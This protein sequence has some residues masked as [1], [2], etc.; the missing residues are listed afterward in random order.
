MLSI[1]REK[2]VSQICWGVENKGDVS[3]SGDGTTPIVEW[4]PTAGGNIKTSTSA[5]DFDKCCG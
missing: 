5:T 1:R 2:D 4:G 3:V